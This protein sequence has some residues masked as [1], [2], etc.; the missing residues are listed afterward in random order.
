MKKIMSKPHKDTSFVSVCCPTVS[1][2][3][4]EQLAVVGFRKRIAGG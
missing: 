3:D 1:Q 4:D 2:L